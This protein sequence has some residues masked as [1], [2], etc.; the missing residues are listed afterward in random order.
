ME[1]K[2]GNYTLRINVHPN[3]PVRNVM[4]DVTI[5]ETRPISLLRVAKVPG[6]QDFL[7]SGKQN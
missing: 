4:V 7:K 1:R 3:Y 6:G 5:H 2:L